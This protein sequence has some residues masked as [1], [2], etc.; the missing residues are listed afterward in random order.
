MSIRAKEVAPFRALSPRQRDVLLDAFTSATAD[1]SPR[2]AKRL[3]E[4]VRRSFFQHTPPPALMAELGISK[5]QFFADRREAFRRLGILF[6][7]AT[8]REVATVVE[9]SPQMLAQARA[10]YRAGQSLR[11][12]SLLDRIDWGSLE[13]GNRFDGLR[14]FSD[15]LDDMDAL[16]AKA[17][18]VAERARRWAERSSDGS[19]PWRLARASEHWLQ[20]RLT[21]VTTGYRRDLRTHIAETVA[22]VRSAAESEDR[23]TAIAFCRM[24]METAPLLVNSGDSENAELAMYEVRA[25]LRRRPDLARVLL[26]EAQMMSSQ[27]HW[28]NLAT[29]SVSRT[30][31]QNA[32]RSA[33][34]SGNVR[35]TWSCLYF[36][37]RDQ[38]LQRNG[39]RAVDLAENFFRSAHASD[40]N[41]RAFSQ[42]TLVNAY[43]M[44]GRIDEAQQSLLLKADTTELPALK[45]AR[46]GVDAARE[47]F[48]ALY[49]RASH[50]VDAFD[51]K[52]LNLPKIVALEFRARAEHHLHKHAAAVADIEDAVAI[53]KAHNS[54][55]PLLLRTLY[56]D[57]FV[58]TG[59]P[60]YRAALRAIVSGAGLHGRPR[61]GERAG[62]LSDR[63]FEVA[64]LAAAGVTNLGIAEELGISPRTVEKHLDAIY[65]RLDVHSRKELSEAL[66]QH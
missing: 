43:L 25:L 66:P 53:S 28:F 44:T 51:Q 36:E 15:A 20:T 3:I 16:P 19:T 14:L 13:P 61:G 6:E 37:I 32:Y 31:R 8:L 42:A 2:R 9:V 21:A 60:E 33:I 63:Q 22:L 62:V 34:E 23:A 18:G 57:A 58:I 12:L 48:S 4:I 27:V 45:L 24:L 7:S 41:M 30:E 39:Q 35:A 40:T 47:N 64:R 38:L 1:L 52:A 11:A 26:A 5:Q 50:L 56:E 54:L 29:L 65:G 17:D 10:L 55:D 46:C 49:D 59:R